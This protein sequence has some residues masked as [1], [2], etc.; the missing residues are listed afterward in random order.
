M[1]EWK[2]CTIGDLCSTI[3]ETYK[4]TDEFVILV[5]TS[6]VL[7][8]K[9]LNHRLVENKKLKG[10]FKKTF[11]K[12]DILYSEIRPANRR[13]AFVDFDNTSN[14][15]ASTKLMVLRHNDAVLPEFL[16]A[17]LKS[18]YI[19]SKLQHLAETRSGTFPQITFSSEL[20]PMKVSF[21]DKKIQ[22][23]IVNIISSIEKKIDINEKINNN[24]LAQVQLL[25]ESIYLSGNTAKMSDLICEIESGSRPKGGALS[26]GIPSIGAEKIESFGSYDFSSEKYI[27]EEFFAKLK[28]GIVKSSDVLLYKDGAYTGKVSMALDGFP[29]E[30]CAVNEHVFILRTY[31]YRFQN[32]LYCCL[33]KKE[34][35][36][37][38]FALASSKAAQ[39]GLN[40]NEVMGIEINLPAEDILTS[41][42]DTVSPL[43]HLV[44]SNANENKRL[45][46]LRDSLLPKLMSGE[47]SVSEIDL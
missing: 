28:R 44:A 26:Q 13:F 11:R 5:N 45:S 16:F 25:F 43:M 6:D 10:Q 30:I 33:S 12:N 27:S 42:E 23:Q 35:R 37:M 9:V 3:S 32:Y 34:I 18:N 22:R 17:L 46:E 14:Y 4:G 20:A 40:Q 15:V 41:F 38:V 47:L 19:I 8:G 24:L 7:D 1:A 29:H 2:E 36:D 31:Y 21:P 39:P